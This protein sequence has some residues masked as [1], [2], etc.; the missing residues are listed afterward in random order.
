MSSCSVRYD[1]EALLSVLTHPLIH[2]DVKLHPANQNQASQ[3]SPLMSE[4]FLPVIVYVHCYTVVHPQFI[5][6]ISTRQELHWNILSTSSLAP[7]KFIN[8]WCRFSASSY[9]IL[10]RQQLM[11][12]IYFFTNKKGG[13]GGRKP[14]KH[15]LL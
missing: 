13:E 12:G 2:K 14:S 6:I 8:S 11:L 9:H 15:N 4:Q 10:N 3:A 7:C 1:T 5:S